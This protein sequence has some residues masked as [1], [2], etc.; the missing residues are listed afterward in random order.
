MA[1]VA[2]SELTERLVNA[3][4]QRRFDH[5]RLRDMAEHYGTKATLALIEK[6]YWVTHALW[7]LHQTGLDIWCKGG[8][9]LSK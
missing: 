9:S 3:L 5:E 1:G 7:A 2:L 6:D 4:R 8:T